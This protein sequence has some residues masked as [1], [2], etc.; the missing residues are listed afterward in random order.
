L[1]K[2]ELLSNAADL[3]EGKRG[4]KPVD[5]QSDPDWLYAKIGQL[6]MELDWLKKVRDQPLKARQQWIQTHK[7]IALTQQCS[8]VGVNRSVVYQQKKRQQCGVNARDPELLN[9]IDE[10]YT[11]HPFLGKR[12]MKL[13]L[14]GLGYTIN[15]KQ[16]QTLMRL[17]RLEGIALGPNTSK[18]HPAHK[19]YP[20]SMREVDIIRPS[21][22]WSTD[23]TYI[24][25]P[26]GFVYLVAIIDRYSRKI[27]SW[28]LSNTMETRF[29]VDCS[30]EAFMAMRFLL[31]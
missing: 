18:S 29:C 26:R 22:V 31:K 10:E 9:L 20:Y 4:P 15:R 25:L 7:S 24:R 14:V 3:F 16:V 21:Q 13:Y 5:A 28:R 30:Q 23:I 11:R 19:I 1:K 6:N 27:L 8:L 2:E 12:R 17:L